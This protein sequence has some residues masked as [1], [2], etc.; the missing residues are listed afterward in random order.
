M[1]DILQKYKNAVGQL[2]HTNGKLL[3]EKKQ[4]HQDLLRQR[5]DMAEALT[6]IDSGQLRAAAEVLRDSLEYRTR[7]REVRRNASGPSDSQHGSK[8]DTKARARAV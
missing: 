5:D 6:L 8:T 2:T 3:A 1:T 7:N 4:M